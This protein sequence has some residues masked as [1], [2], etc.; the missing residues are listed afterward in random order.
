MEK[1]IS[2]KNLNLRIGNKEVLN[3]INFDIEKGES[4]VIVG[5]SGC[6]KTVLIKTILGIIKPYKGEIYIFGKN[7]ENLREDELKEIRE[8][9]GMVFQNSALFDSLSVWENVGFYYL[10]HTNRRKEDIKNQAIEI[11]KS[12]GLDESVS[13]MMPE[14]LSGGMKKRVSIARALISKPEIIFYD[15]PTTGLDPITSENLTSLI[16]KIHQEFNTTDITIT[17]DVKLASKIG[18]KLILIDQGRIVEVGTYEELRKKSKH[19][20]IRSYVEMG[21]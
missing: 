9:I 10:Y 17:H 12:L 13:D 18:K 21:G 4:V 15:E 3:D 19:P 14:Q 6:G 7:I 20:I 16:K 1:I 8:K 5:P 2:V 11:L